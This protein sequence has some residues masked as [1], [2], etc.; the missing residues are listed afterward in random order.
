[1]YSLLRSLKELNIQEKLRLRL[2]SF[3]TQIE[4]KKQLSS[5]IGRKGI[6]YLAS[7]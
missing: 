6:I 1:M 3:L 7:L 2:V 5:I 4:D